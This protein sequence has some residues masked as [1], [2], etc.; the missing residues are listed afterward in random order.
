M[1]R[2][3][4]STLRTVRF[5]EEAGLLRPASRSDGGH[6]MFD[7][8]ELLKLQ[9]ILDL[10]EACLS[11]SDI[12]ELF[13]LKNTCKSAEEASGLM[14]A[15]LG[16]QID[17][18]QTKITKLRR[19]REELASTVSVIRECEGCPSTQFPGNCGECEMLERADLPRAVKLLWG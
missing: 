18:M 19:L 13:D 9:L 15:I 4:E 5:Y 17:E 1:A 12:K 10:R 6:R 16:R 2:L 8:R 14:S 3:T 11:L 7:E